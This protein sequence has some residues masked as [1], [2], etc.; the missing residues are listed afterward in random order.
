MLPNVM[1]G[2][3]R[4][5]SS[6][7]TSVTSATVAVIEITPLRSDGARALGALRSQRFLEGPTR[8]LVLDGAHIYGRYPSRHNACIPWNIGS[9]TAL[10]MAAGPGTPSLSGGSVTLLNPRRAGV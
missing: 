6:S 7:L 9:A 3:R 8:Y 2:R 5:S 10:S 4:S 1:R